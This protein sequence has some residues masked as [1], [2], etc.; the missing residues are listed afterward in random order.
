[1]VLFIFTCVNLSP[2]EPGLQRISQARGN[3]AAVKLRRTEYR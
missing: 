3:M 1:M 2:P